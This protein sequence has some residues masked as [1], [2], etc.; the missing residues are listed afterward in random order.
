MGKYRCCEG[1]EHGAA[2]RTSRAVDTCTTRAMEDVEE[3]FDYSF[4]QPVAGR[5]MIACANAVDGLRVITVL[6]FEP[7]RTVFWVS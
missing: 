1:P 6:V 4:G 5:Q 3:G 7:I 2:D